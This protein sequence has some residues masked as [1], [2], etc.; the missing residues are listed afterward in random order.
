MKTYWQLYLD[1]FK[2]NQMCLSKGVNILNNMNL[3]IVTLYC[4]A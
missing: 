4:S 3:N 2:E 1:D